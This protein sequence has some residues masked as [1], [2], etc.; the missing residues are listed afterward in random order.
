LTTDSAT[1]SLFQ[2]DTVGTA[3]IDA[4]NVFQI[5]GNGGTAVGSGPACAK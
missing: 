4:A 5:L 1:V 3:Q 2:M